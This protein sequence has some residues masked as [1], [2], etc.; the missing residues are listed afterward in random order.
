MP[1]Q[2]KT[3]GL[4][5]NVA[6]KVCVF[7]LADIKLYHS[8]RENSDSNQTPPINAFIVIGPTELEDHCSK[9]GEFTRALK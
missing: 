9:P 6:H 1:Q 4:T 7:T 2:N 8:F 3:C 5:G